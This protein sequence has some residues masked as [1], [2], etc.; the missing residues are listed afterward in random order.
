MQLTS[1]GLVVVPVEQESH[2]EGVGVGFL[3]RYGKQLWPIHLISRRHGNCRPIPCHRPAR[4]NLNTSGNAYYYIDYLHD[5]IL[6][7]CNASGSYIPI[8][9][10]KIVESC[11]PDPCRARQIV[12]VGLTG[13]D[14]QVSCR[15]SNVRHLRP[16]AQS[17]G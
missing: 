16:L 2:V 6:S 5:L 3:I 11:I 10:S 8:F 4:M 7:A 13:R 17:I 12:A 9:M 15:T 1:L 14:E